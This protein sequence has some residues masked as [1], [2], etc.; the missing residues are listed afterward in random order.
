MD[1]ELVKICIHI[2]LVYSVETRIMFALPL[3]VAV[4]YMVRVLY[5]GTSRRLRSLD[6][7]SRSALYSSFIET[8]GYVDAPACSFDPD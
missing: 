3:C 8:V 6:M 4:L 5:I 7:E 2:L 1:L